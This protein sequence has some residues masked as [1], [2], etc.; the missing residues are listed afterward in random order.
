ME[1]DAKARN[2][3]VAHLEAVAQH[4]LE[5]GGE[6]VAPGVFELVAGGD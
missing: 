5:L 1:I 6:G 2:A 3:E 4:G